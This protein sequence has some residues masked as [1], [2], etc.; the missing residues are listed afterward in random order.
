M[1]I[2]CDKCSSEFTLKKLSKSTGKCPQCGELIPVSK[3]CT[4]VP[5]T[6]FWRL[7]SAAPKCIRR[8]ASAYGAN[9]AFLI[10]TIASV[11][12]ESYS[13]KIVG[14][15]LLLFTLGLYLLCR[16]V[17]G[18]IITAAAY[19][20]LV[21]VI[22]LLVNFYRLCPANFYDEGPIRIDITGMAATVISLLISGVI[23][24]FPTPWLDAHSWGQQ[25]SEEKLAYK[26]AQ[27]VSALSEIKDH[28]YIYKPWVSANRD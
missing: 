14:Y 21:F 18:Q 27:K 26:L 28:G 5:E 10:V 13:L 9:L 6:R 4:Y 23:S 1:I 16:F 7:Y 12:L 25:N 22:L 3:Y 15:G 19:N 11:N 8:T 20:I 24:L 2:T 17:R